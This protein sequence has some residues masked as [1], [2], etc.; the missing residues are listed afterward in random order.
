MSPNSRFRLRLLAHTG[1]AVRV[2][3]RF[4]YPRKH[5]NV[6]RVSRLQIG[7]VNS[8]RKDETMKHIEGEVTIAGDEGK[9]N[10]ELQSVMQQVF[11]THVPKIPPTL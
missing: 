4:K 8:T 7:A 5:W 2:V 9:S 1:L 3:C 11:C 10:M 6:G